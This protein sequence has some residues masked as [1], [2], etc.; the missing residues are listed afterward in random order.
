MAKSKAVRYSPDMV[1]KAK[2]LKAK[3]ATQEE[4]AIIFGVTSKTIRNW[5]H[6]YPDFAAAIEGPASD[7]AA[8]HFNSK[9][10]EAMDEQARKL[11]LLGYTNAEMA[12]FF[13][14]QP[15][16]IDNWLAQI[17]SFRKSVSAGKAPAD[18]LVAESLY[19]RGRGYSHP[20]TDIR[21]IDNQVVKTEYVKHH[22]PDTA[23]AIFWLCNRSPKGWQ[24]RRQL[25]VENAETLTAWSSVTAGVDESGEEE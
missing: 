15:A 10:T 11:C 13:N 20:A 1:E 14:V 19:Q 7:G 18:A 12:L 23:A 9:Y 5:A 25:F 22:P 21:V 2:V 24:N 6:R 16:T 3:K 17:P 4:M 8:G